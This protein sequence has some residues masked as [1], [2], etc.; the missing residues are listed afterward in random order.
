M[1]INYYKALN[2]GFFKEYHHVTMRDEIRGDMVSMKNS[3]SVEFGK[4]KDFFFEF[5]IF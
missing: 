4:K 2:Y 1:N 3:S 5:R